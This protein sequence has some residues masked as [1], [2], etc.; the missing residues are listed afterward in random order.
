MNVLFSISKFEIS[1]FV[2]I[3]KVCHSENRDFFDPRSPMSHFFLF[4]LTPSPLFN[5]LKINKYQIPNSK[6][7]TEVKVKGFMKIHLYLQTVCEN[8][9]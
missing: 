4:A 6:W 9:I 5:P 3:Q 8:K 2:I 7:L 1:F